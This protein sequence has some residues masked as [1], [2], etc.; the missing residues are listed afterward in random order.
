MWWDCLPIV[1]EN[2]VVF[3]SCCVGDS[4]GDGEKLGEV[5]VGDVEEFGA[6]VFGDYELW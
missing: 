6:V 1:L 3:Y 2:V 5:F 4:F